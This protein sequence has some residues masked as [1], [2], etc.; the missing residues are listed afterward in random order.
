MIQ[1]RLFAPFNSLMFDA[2]KRRQRLA[3]GLIVASIIMAPSM[4][5]LPFATI[6]A[7]IVIVLPRRAS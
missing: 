7:A 5:A 3:V 4:S 6:W 2:D 1:P